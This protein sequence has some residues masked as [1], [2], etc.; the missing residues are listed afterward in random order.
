MRTFPKFSQLHRALL[1]AEKDGVKIES[2][3][4]KAKHSRSIYINWNDAVGSGYIFD[5][6][7]NKI[8]KVYP[9]YD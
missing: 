8:R 7:T 6:A 3:F 2:F 4:I 5:V 9:D 1:A